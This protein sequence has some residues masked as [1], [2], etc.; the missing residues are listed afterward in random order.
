[1]LSFEIL[2][3]WSFWIL[4]R[5]RAVVL[6][7]PG[8]YNRSQTLH[9]S[10]DPY[11]SLT[12][13]EAASSRPGSWRILCLVRACSWFMY[14]H[15]GEGQGGSL[16]SLLY[17]IPSW[18]LHYHP[19]GVGVNIWVWGNTRIRSRAVA[20]D[21]VKF[22]TFKNCQRCFPAKKIVAATLKHPEL[23]QWHYRSLKTQTPRFL[24]GPQTSVN[25]IAL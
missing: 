25:T 24:Q 8:C 9:A 7:C 11:R 21:K 20:N 6:P 5:F 13:P 17:L 14:P 1:M 4:C 18:G 22:F 12:A 3:R 2:T 16:G 23:K 19:G 15:M 10:N